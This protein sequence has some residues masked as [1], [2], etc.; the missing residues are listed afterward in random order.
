MDNFISLIQSRMANNLQNSDVP[1]LQRQ[2]AELDALTAQLKSLSPALIALH[3]QNVLLGIYKSHLGA[4]RITVNGQYKSGWNTLIVRLAILG[5][6]IA[7]LAVLSQIAYRVSERHIHDANRR[8]VLAVVQGTGLLLVVVLVTAFA[9]AS[10]LSSLATFFGLV[11]A[12]IAV[13][14]QNVILASAGYLLLVGKRGVRI[15]DRVRI[16]D[17]TGDV[18][19]IGLLQF[20]LKEYEQQSQTYTGQIATF[21]NSF[22]FLTPATGLLKLSQGDLKLASYEVENGRRRQ[23]VG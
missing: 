8:R 1:S 4:W 18:I 14:L 23:A 6:I 15:G 13:A 2:K 17:I 20:Q 3:K 5:V 21:S 10:D 19:D 12:G 22:V 9:L 7:L 11:T 16:S